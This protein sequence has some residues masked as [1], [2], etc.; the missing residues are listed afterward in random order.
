MGKDKISAIPRDW[1][2]SSPPVSEAFGSFDVPADV[3][4]LLSIKE[5]IIAF[6]EGFAWDEVNKNIISFHTV[7]RRIR[8][9]RQEVFSRSRS[10]NRLRVIVE[11]QTPNLGA[12]RRKI[13]SCDV[14]LD[15]RIIIEETEHVIVLA[16]DGDLLALESLRS[17]ESGLD[18]SEPG[19][20]A[21]VRQIKNVVPR[22]SRIFIVSRPPREEKS[23]FHE[24]LLDLKTR[25]NTE[26]YLG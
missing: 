10:D 25:E 4:E 20:H 9:R 3:K 24:L 5:E 13:Q 15:G 18:F 8:I 12:S 23:T 11:S 26:W 22:E 21:K 1:I 16:P 14:D 2:L 17:L 6:A 7:G 19:K